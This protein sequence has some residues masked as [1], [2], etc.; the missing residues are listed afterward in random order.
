MIAKPEFFEPHSSQPLPG[1]TRVYVAGQIHADVRVPMRE[2]ALSA[3]KSLIHRGRETMKRK[4]RP[5]LRT[6][7]WLGSAD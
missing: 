5:Y 6:G 3:T 4:L 2:I 1:S 7:V